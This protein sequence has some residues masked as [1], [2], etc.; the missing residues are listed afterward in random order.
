MISLKHRFLFIHIPKTAGNSLQNI[1]RDYSEDQIVCLAPHQDGFERFEVR[2]QTFNIHKHSTLS[3]YRQQLGDDLL[4]QL[5]K[6]ACVRNPWDRMVSFYFSPHRGKVE[7][8]RQ[9]FMNHV[10]CVP[11]APHF[12]RLDANDT[13]D[14]FNNVDFVLRFESLNEDFKKVCAHVGIEQRELPKRNSSVHE[15]YSRYY[16]DELIDLVAR[17]YQPEIQRFGYVFEKA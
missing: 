17:R 13:S 15:H 4:K 14:T 2:N 12:L 10:H 16:D 9:G 7:W 11:G 1:L 5:Y 6:F 3:D 8:D